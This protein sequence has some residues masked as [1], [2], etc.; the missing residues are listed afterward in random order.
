VTGILPLGYP[1]TMPRSAD[2]RGPWVRM[3]QLSAAVRTVEAMTLVALAAG[4]QRW[5]PMVKW[6]WALGEAGPVPADWVASDSSE[7]A[8]GV[9]SQVERQVRAAVQRACM[10][11]PF[12]PTCLARAAAGQVMLRHRGEPGTVVIGL[13]K[14]A[15]G[16]ALP[17]PVPSA[18]AAHAWLRGSAGILLGG[19]EAEGFTP[20]TVFRPPSQ[21]ASGPHE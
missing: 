16:V 14:S 13:R 8:I 19:P 10:S 18:W 3:R 12:E 20:T 2:I 6:S 7:A 4:A 17:S 21:S 5:V 15:S 11:L 1:R 9:E